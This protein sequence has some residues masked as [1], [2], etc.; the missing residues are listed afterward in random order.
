MLDRFRADRREA[1]TVELEASGVGDLDELL[2]G[3]REFPTSDDP[4]DLHWKTLAA[5]TQEYVATLDDESKQIVALR[6]EDELSQDEVA[7]RMRCTRRRVR[8][9]EHQ[10][11]D[12]LRR[13]LKGRKLLDS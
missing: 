3:G 9:V 13:W 6:F 5:A 8:T 4:P 10:V 1:R 11:Q 12:G 2:A 7:A